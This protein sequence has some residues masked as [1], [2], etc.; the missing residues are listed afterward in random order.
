M[1][2][3]AHRDVAAEGAVARALG[4]GTADA[5]GVGAR[6]TAGRV[7]S[8]TVGGTRFGTTAVSR[9]RARSRRA[10]L[11]SRA[12]MLSSATVPAL[13]VTAPVGAACEVL[14]PRPPRSTYH[15]PPAIASRP[16][17]ARAAGSRRSGPARET[18]SAAREEGT[19]GG[20]AG[21]EGAVAA[22]AGAE[23]RRA[24]ISLGV[25][26]ATA[27]GRRNF[28]VGSSP[29]VSAGSYRAC[30]STGGAL[31]VRCCRNSSTVCQ[32]RFG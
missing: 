8:R 30:E 7:V 9:G 2:A 23:G 21:V 25:A 5:G 16:I 1:D 14:G 26:A 20:G 10:T 12:R 19:G 4:A 18:G 17:S 24:G 11:L 28:I 3:L 22:G 32:R 15:D 6:A 31:Y 29:A 27:D 13:D